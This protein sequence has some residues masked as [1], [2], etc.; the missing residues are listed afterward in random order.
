MA[1]QVNVRI[2]EPCIYSPIGG[3]TRHLAVGETLAMSVEDALEIVSQNRGVAA[4][5]NNNS[6]EAEKATG[7]K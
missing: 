5:L 1:D 2:V 4:S 7:K 3:K 6:D